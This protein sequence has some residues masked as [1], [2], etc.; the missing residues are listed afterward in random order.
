[1]KIFKKWW[2]WVIA[3]IVIIVVIPKD[4]SSTKDTTTDNVATSAA[5]AT[6]KV[7]DEI[8]ERVAEEI[9]TTPWIKAGMYKAGTDIQA[10]EYV[11][12]AESMAY[13]QVSNDSTGSLDSIVSNDNFSGNRYITVTDGQYIEITNAKML[14]VD[15]AKPI[16]PADG[17]YADGMYK[18]GRDI[19]AGEY[20]V[21]PTGT[22]YVEVANDSTGTLDGIVTNDNIEA[23]KYI[24]V[25]DGQYL[26][27]V[28]CYI[29]ID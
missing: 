26:K 7:A 15:D 16:E 2:F 24:T 27:L 14:T 18:V 13:Y 6:Q 25:A 20:K 22:A 3:I 12:Y 8:T 4:N 23:E 11:I 19:K 29:A 5:N 1:M 10:G 21:V 9:D 17:K 28:S